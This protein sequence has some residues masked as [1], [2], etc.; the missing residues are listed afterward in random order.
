MKGLLLK[1][2]YMT[3]KYY[4]MSLLIDMVF[5][6]VSFFSNEN[7][8]FLIFPVIISGV[9]PVT[10][11]A[12][13][14]KFK[15][16]HY[17]GALPYSAAQLVSAKY[18]FGLIVQAATSLLIFAAIMVRGNFVEGADIS[19]YSAAQMVGGMFIISLVMPALCLPFCYK[20]GTEKGR[21]VYFIVMF[22]LSALAW[23]TMGG[24][25]NL[26]EIKNLFLIL[27]T[28]VVIYA[29]SWIVSIAVYGRR[30]VK[31]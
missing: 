10:L 29:L 1:E 17:S 11:L 27:G 14:E 4:K 25:E 15:W 31:D 23:K 7:L 28:I 19:L 16:T 22:G 2:F 18:L 12:Y 9:L 30:K 21:I 8:A 26:A 5:I 24:V 6:A 3:V 13:D 20:F